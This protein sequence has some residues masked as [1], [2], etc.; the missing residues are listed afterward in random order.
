MG[1]L[2]ELIS[3]TFNHTLLTRLGRRGAEW[4][5]QKIENEGIIVV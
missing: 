3:P 2:M 1:Q 5:W 4:V